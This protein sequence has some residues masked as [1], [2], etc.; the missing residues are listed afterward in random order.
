MSLNNLISKQKLIEKNNR[1]QT[2][3]CLISSKTHKNE[4]E[5]IEIFWTPPVQKNT[6]KK[7]N[8]FTF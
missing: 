2:L 4:E 5:F 3:F 6:Y 7:P 8:I 1:H